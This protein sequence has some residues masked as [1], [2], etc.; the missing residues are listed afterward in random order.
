ME[1]G[2]AVTVQTAMIIEADGL[3][4]VSVRVGKSEVRAYFF[5]KGGKV[6]MGDTLR[7][8]WAG[9]S[10][11]KTTLAELRRPCEEGSQYVHQGRAIASALR[12]WMAGRI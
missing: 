10:R 4:E 5:R 1:S 11:G 12:G 9:G 6:E 2:A 3:G 7:L 8:F